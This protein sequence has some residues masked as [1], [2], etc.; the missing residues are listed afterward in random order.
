MGRDTWCVHYNGIANSETCKAGVNYESVRKG[1]ALPCIQELNPDG[2]AQCNQCRMPT[3]EEIEERKKLTQ[4]RM[5][6]LHKARLAIVAD[7]GGPFKKGDVY[8]KGTI[9]CPV[10]KGVKT[11]TYQRSSYNGHIQAKCSTPECVRW[12]E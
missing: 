8:R 5:I 3:K 10:C 11:L 7:C 12:I 1:S 4:R 9:D 2:V 6:D